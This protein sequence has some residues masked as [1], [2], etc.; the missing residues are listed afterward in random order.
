MPDKPDSACLESLVRADYERCHPGETFEDLKRR[1]R[2][3]AD[4]KG[5]LREWMTLAQQRAAK[6][7]AVEK[8]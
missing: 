7:D 5:L 6:R 2:F 4:D 1:A 3:A 8:A